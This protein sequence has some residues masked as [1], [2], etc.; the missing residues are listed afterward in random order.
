MS[1]RRIQDVYWE[2]LLGIS[3]SK[4]LKSVSDKSISHISNLTNEG[5]SKM[6]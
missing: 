1:S 5:E 3:V 2:Y 4:Y 6:H